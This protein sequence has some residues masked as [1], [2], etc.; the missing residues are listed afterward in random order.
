MRKVE[1]KGASEKAS[2]LDYMAV[3]MRQQQQQ[4]IDTHVFI[5]QA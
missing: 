1:S 2:P 3:N 5:S 4:L